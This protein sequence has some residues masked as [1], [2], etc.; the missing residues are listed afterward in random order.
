MDNLITICLTTYNRPNYLKIAI[1]S[2]IEQSFEEFALIILDNGSDNRTSELIASYNDSR[3]S[4]VK[5]QKNE[6]EFIN[7]AFT[8]S[9]NKYLMLT[10]DDD[11]MNSN[12]LKNQIK[13]LENDEEIGV[14]AS[15]IN[16]IDDDGNELNRIRPR[17]LQNRLWLEKEFIKEYFFRGDII[18]CPTCIFRS[19]IISA[20]NLKYNFE[21]GQAVDLFLLFKINLLDTKIF[22]TKTPLYNYRIHKNQD[23]ELNRINLEI[24]IRPHIIKLLKRKEEKD[25]L[26]HYKKSSSAIIFHIILNQFL[27]NK[28]SLKKFKK[29]LKHE[30]FILD[31]SLN[32]YSVLWT[33]VSIF[34]SIRDLIFKN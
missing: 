33:F 10:H 16:L 17:I 30:V 2:I 18:P 15:R 8:Y 19:D 13:I 9:N 32:Q 4:Y 1:D 6:R 23:S 20:N 7:Q 34:R 25:L 3:I 5:N 29:L 22:L 21:V 28:I 27:T 24:S 26:R 11:V 14:L 31:L 12:F